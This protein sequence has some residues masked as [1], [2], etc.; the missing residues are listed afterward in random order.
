[1]FI[2]FAR[3]RVTGGA[4]GAGACAFRREKGVPR[5]GPSGGDGGRGGDVYLRADPNL[6]T[7]LDY[8]YR[9]HYQAGPGGHGEGKDRRGADGEDLILPVPPGTVVREAGSSERVGEL[10]EPGELLRVARGGRGGRGNASFATSTR[11][12]PRE[13]EP[14]EWG[15][16]RRIELELKL[17]ADVGLVGEPNA[18]K[19]TFLAAVSAARPKIAAYPFTTLEP[20]L[21][22][23]AL[24]DGRSYVVADIPGIVED[25][26]RGKGLGTQ[27]LRHI[28]RTRIL[29]LLLPIDLPDRQAAYD[30]LRRE[31]TEHD[32]ALAEIPHCVLVTKADLVPEEERVPGLEA[33]GAWGT[34]VLSSATG[35][36]VAPVM[37]ALWRRLQ[38]E[39]ARIAS[40]EGKAA[41]FPDA[42][43]TGR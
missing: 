43:S 21:G 22:V 19:S 12:A 32:A 1:M 8:T 29:A 9:E 14:G 18:G 20:N 39:R 10:L 38:E 17:I 42:G 28:E 15:E 33:R 4:G 26:H 31:L 13:W 2:D 3:I 27:F 7:L 6:G 23:V 36:G 25:A 41:P 11:Q 35:E 30:L 40:V 16:E 34:F 5:G 37:E 24:T